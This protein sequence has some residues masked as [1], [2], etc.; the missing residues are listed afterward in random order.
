MG[1]PWVYLAILL[2]LVSAALSSVAL[3]LVAALIL[4]LAAVIRLW[5]KY[6]LTRVEYHHSLSSYRA[7]TGEEVVL[8]TELSNGKFLPMPWV[9]V[10]DEMP[11]YAAP[12]QGRIV[13]SPEQGR[14]ILATLLSMSW[15]YKITRR[16]S[17]VCQRRGHYY[18]GPTEVRSGDLFGMF[19]REMRQGRDHLL[20]VYPRVLPLVLAR[21]ASR[22][23]YG[24]VRLRNSLI[25]DLS[26]PMGSREYVVGDSLRHIHWKAF[27]RTG[28]LQTR[29]FDASTTPNFVMFYGVRTVEQPLQG[30]R[31][32]L[33]ELGILTVTALAN[34]ALERGLS[35]GTYVNQTSRLTSKLLQSPPAA[36]P[37][38]LTHILELMAQVHPEESE[39][40]AHMLSD[41][42]RTL[43]WGATILVVTAVV[44]EATYATMTHLRRAGRAVALVKIG[45]EGEPLAGLGIPT[46]V[47]SGAL[48]WQKMEQVVLS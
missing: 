11:Q 16:Y 15:Y 23:P 22:D 2:A 20:L 5:V 24:S 43:P 18:L 33:L 7:F 41:R 39:S 44:D 17:V 30:S 4:V 21:F 32:H 34:Y 26:R 29:V 36:S 19:S 47:V 42:S 46:Y 12:L 3:L 8:T 10:K 27:A 25:D 28:Q 14:V 38:Q 37:E 9:Q 6:C 35:V 31:P 1:T 40:L 13:P 45:D 48:D